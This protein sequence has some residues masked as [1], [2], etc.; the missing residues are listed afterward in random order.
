MQ[1]GGLCM[2]FGA[3]HLWILIKKLRFSKKLLFL[4]KNALFEDNLVHFS[5]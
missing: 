2:V 4:V 1:N 5:S 3:F